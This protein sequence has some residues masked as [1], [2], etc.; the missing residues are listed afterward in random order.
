[1]PYYEV[2]NKQLKPPVSTLRKQGFPSVIFVDDSYL[3]GNTETECEDNVQATIFLHRK[4]GFTINDVQ[5][6][7]I[8]T[9]VIEFLEFILSSLDMTIEL[10][11]RK[12][13]N[14]KKK[15]IEL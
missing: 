13:V 11:E 10:N 9:Q 2:I 6:I 5:L 8:Q 4:L 3:Q 12:I 14:I 7:L 15:I 1:M